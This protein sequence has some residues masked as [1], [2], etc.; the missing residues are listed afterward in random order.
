MAEKSSIGARG[1]SWSCHRT[2]SGNERS[3]RLAEK[4]Q[5]F[6]W[7]ADGRWK[8]SG[9]LIALWWRERSRLC[10]LNGGG[11]RSA[12]SQRAHLARP[13]PE[14]PTKGGCKSCLMCV[15]DRVGYTSDW[16]TPLTQQRQSMLHAAADRE[17]ENCF[18]EYGL[19]AVL[20]GGLVH[21]GSSGYLTNSW[22]G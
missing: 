19:E 1:S 6:Y 13:D 14:M 21:A 11:G 8:S 18:A 17:L 9:A 4:Y 10:L 12:G 2:R 16:H 22:N 3:R 5:V 15:P 7:S 20:Q